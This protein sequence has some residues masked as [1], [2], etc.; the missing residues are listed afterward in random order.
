MLAKY[1]VLAMGLGLG[2]AHAGGIP[3]SNYLGFADQAGA[4]ST[5][6]G[7]FGAIGQV[8]LGECLGESHF[9]TFLFSFLFRTLIRMFA[10]IRFVY[11]NDVADAPV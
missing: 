4:A 2:G 3:V 8:G 6:T 5:N 7:V 10:K 9:C 1:G 11:R